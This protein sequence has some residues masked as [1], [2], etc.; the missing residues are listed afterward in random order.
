[1]LRADGG[2]L[3]TL[4]VGGL[5][6][7]GGKGAGVTEAGLGVNAL[8]AAAPPGL[9]GREIR[10]V[11]FLILPWVTLREG[12][13][14]GAVGDAGTIGLAGTTCA[15]GGA[16]AAGAGGADTARAAAAIPEEMA[17]VCLGNDIPAGISGF[18]V[19]RFGG[20]AGSL[21]PAGKF[22]FGGGGGG[23]AILPST[24][25]KRTSPSIT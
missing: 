12:L 7:L 16:G 10:I 11:S 9:G 22:G 13:G 17:M 1:M 19:M 25:L 15:G 24:M 20:V 2:A 3:S 5:I 4:E 18:W 21:A 6:A 14:N 8:A 23:R